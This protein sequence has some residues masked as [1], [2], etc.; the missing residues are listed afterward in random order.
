MKI[1]LK[2]WSTNTGGYYEQARLLYRDGVFDYIELYVV[3]D[4]VD[5]L[6]KWSELGVPFSI[7]AP[8][9][10][11][12]FNL[13]DET[14]KAFNQKVYQEVKVF[15]DKLGADVIVFHGGVDGCIEETARQLKALHEPR[16]LLENKPYWALPDKSN[17]FKH[18]RG[19]NTEEISYVMEEAQCGFCFDFV[20]A[21]CA[22]NAQKLDV[23][24]YLD[25]FFRLN[26][27]Y[28]H[29]SDVLDL[30][31]EYDSHAHLGEGSLDIGWIK[32]KIQSASAVTIETE[33]TN[34]SDL[35]DFRKDVQ[36]LKKLG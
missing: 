10:M 31:S 21:V 3:P 7:H 18:C 20:H 26:P 8:H 19:F 23:Y 4:T 29:L 28:F 27:D 25:Q 15:A 17:V 9:S 32:N 11:N 16:A 6:G 14:K 34:L 33:K 12:G 22:A 1:G 35:D 2:L 5:T 36:W 24:S 30:S 13:A